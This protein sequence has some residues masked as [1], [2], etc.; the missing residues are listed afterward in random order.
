MGAQTCS[1]CGTDV[2]STGSA[3]PCPSCGGVRRDVAID[4]DTVRAVASVGAPSIGIGL[5]DRTWSDKW[6]R[7]MFHYSR[8]QA[9]Y[10]EALKVS[11]EEIISEVEV[12]FLRCAHMQEWLVSDQ[13]IPTITQPI[14]AQYV[15][16]RPTLVI[17]RGFANSDKHM[18]RSDP[19]ALVA[20]VQTFWGTATGPRVMIEYGVPGEQ[21][22]EVDALD[23]A[24]ACWRTWRYF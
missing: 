1:D 22:T 5:P 2:S 12:F 21:T 8:L 11:R 9:I 17:C 18:V 6:R 4:V 15:A 24:T 14:V 13:T 3:T 23:L 7:T 20:T 16:S 10:G 19:K